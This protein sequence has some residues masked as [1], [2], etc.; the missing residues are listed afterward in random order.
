[1]IDINIALDPVNDGIVQNTEQIT[2]ISKG[3]LII[4]TNG[5]TR[6]VNLERIPY[7]LEGLAD[8]SYSEF[9]GDTE[10]LLIFN[11]NKIFNVG[12]GRF[13][14]G[15][16]LVMKNDD[17]ELCPMTREECGKASKEFQSRLATLVCDGQEFTAYE[18]EY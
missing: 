4:A 16:V 1:M 9:M 11:A 2:C 3:A 13:F 5:K 6:F 12:T 17:G 18:L 8:L 14:V 10:Y 15:S 7:E